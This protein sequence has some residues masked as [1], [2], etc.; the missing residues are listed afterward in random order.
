[1]NFK[2]I[3]ALLLFSFLITEASAQI[4]LKQI[5]KD[6]ERSLN[7]RAERAVERK[8]DDV[9]D[10]AEDKVRGRNKKKNKNDGEKY[11]TNG[12]TKIIKEVLPFNFSGNLTINIQ[13]TGTIEDNLIKVVSNEY[14][15]AVRPMLVKKPHNLI[16]YNK[17]EEAATRIN[18]ELYDDKALKEFHTYDKVEISKSN[19]EL[20]RTSDIK[21]IDGYIARKYIVEGNDYEGTMWIS[22]EVDLDYDLFSS[23]MEFQSLDIGTMYGFPLEMHVSFE[24]GDTMDFFVKSVE[25]G[26]PDKALFDVSSYDLIDMT[27]LKSGN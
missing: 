3:I 2:T 6:T 24:N 7:N 21:E 12:E 22:A 18:T 23:L 14:D 19:T 10:N 25:D 17:Q 15:L 26:N 1:M 11:D 4:D 20:E 9:L 16:V 27:D 5:V 8:V 13:G